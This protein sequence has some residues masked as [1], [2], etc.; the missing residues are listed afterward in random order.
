MTE[1]HMHL[2]LIIAVLYF[3]LLLSNNSVLNGYMT[4]CM[5]AIATGIKNSLGE[6][7]LKESSCECFIIKFQKIM[8]KMLQIFKNLTI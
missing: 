1:V 2:S 5:T 3:I 4:I 6:H 7:T 8:I